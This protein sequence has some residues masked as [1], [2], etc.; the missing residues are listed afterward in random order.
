MRRQD[1]SEIREG[2]G[3]KAGRKGETERREGGREGG[4][5]Y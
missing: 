2:G 5:T 1:G 4:G 3:S